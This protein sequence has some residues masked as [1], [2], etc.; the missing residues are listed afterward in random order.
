MLVP[1]Q[2]HACEICQSKLLFNSRCPEKGWWEF[3]TEHESSS[4]NEYGYWF[5]LWYG[6][7]IELAKSGC[8]LMTWLVTLRRPDTTSD[9]QL[10]AYFIHNSEEQ[11][12]LDWVD[13]ISQYTDSKD[14]SRMLV[15]CAEV[16]NVAA[17]EIKQRLPNLNPS[18]GETMSTAR[19]WLQTCAG[20]HEACAN[21][22]FGNARCATADDQAL[23]PRRLIKISKRPAG[24]DISVQPVPYL[25]DT[26]YI[27]SPKY[28]TLSYCW[29]GDQEFKLLKRNLIPWHSQI[30]LN[31]LPQTI[32][33]AMLVTIELEL[34]YL[35]VDALCI[36]QDD[37]ADKSV[38]LARMA[39]IYS[40][41][42]ITLLASRSSGARDG[43][44]NSRY[45]ARER[46]YRLPYLCTDG[47]MG[48]VVLWRGRDVGAAEPIHQ[49]GWCFQE[50]ILS[51]RILEFGTHQLR[52]LCSANRTEHIA[53]E[54]DGWV[55]NS[56]TFAQY[57]TGQSLDL[58]ASWY[59]LPADGID[60]LNLWSRIV[61]H[62]SHLSLSYSSDRLRAISAIARKLGQVSSV[63]YYA[64]LWAEHL[65]SQLLWE[66]DQG[67][68]RLQKA[69]RIAEYVAPS[70]S[71][72][73][74][75]GPVCCSWIHGDCI[76]YQMIN[77]VIH[78][79]TPSD[80]FS[81]VVSAEIR[82]RTSTLYAKLTTQERPSSPWWP[83][84]L[85]DELWSVKGQED[86]GEFRLPLFMDPESGEEWSEI[87]GQWDELTL[88]DHAVLLAQ[89]ILGRGLI[90]EVQPHSME[91]KYRR[92]GTF[93]LDTYAEED[94]RWKQRDIVIV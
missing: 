68:Y 12:A 93:R 73:S 7:A 14:F 75:Q 61:T 18:S 76:A 33:D 85:V 89:I 80:D 82:L 15:L 66:T 4:G 26:R 70:W 39:D 90:L 10:R 29:G 1:S 92:V 51:P 23:R 22:G 35:W 47:Q 45:I 30:P 77:V 60:F 72:A 24:S 87:S 38:E 53:P 55:T 13:E 3:I 56:E 67:E 41:A 17:A 59:T 34:E 57:G 86:A 49:R 9:S 65:S 88:G 27:P 31:N 40:E 36:I 54:T 11:L 21:R 71:W 25:V 74:M 19:A 16:D 43:F 58:S 69:T 94:D 37:N 48:S 8:E 83:T 20:T 44:L 32:K 78:N 63:R 62:Y 64:G 84:Y 50:Q 28:A 46:G 79:S 6:E 42:H 81:D 91:K 5:N 2:P 52:Y